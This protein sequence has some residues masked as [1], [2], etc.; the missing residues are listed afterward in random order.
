MANICR[1]NIIIKA[2]KTAIDNFV[3]RFDKCVDGT[4]PNTEDDRPHIIDEFGAKAELLI[5]RIGSKWVSM[6]DGGIN[7]HDDTE[8]SSEVHLAL[9]SAWY[10]PSDMILE[11][12]R[13]MEEIDG[14][15]EGVRVYGSYWDEG[16]QPIG[17]FEVYHGQIIEEENHDLD[18]SEWESTLNDGLEEEGESEYDRNFWE[19][20]VEP[21]FEIIKKKLDKVMKD[22]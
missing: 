21:A 22:I 9:D 18:W 12:F 10:P 13:Q 20:E 19:E 14:V 2:S 17:V 6:W 11:M 4:Y 7:Y 5:D 16:Y 3:E 15:G 1:T 8:G